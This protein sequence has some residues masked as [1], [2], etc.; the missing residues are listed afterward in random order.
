MQIKGK[1]ALNE[2]FITWDEKRF[3]SGEYIEDGFSLMTRNTSSLGSMVSLSEGLSGGWDDWWCQFAGWQ[4]ECTL[5]VYDTGFAPT[6]FEAGIL[7]ARTA[8][9][10]PEDMEK[11][12]DLSWAM[13]YFDTEMGMSAIYEG[14][15]LEPLSPKFVSEVTLTDSWYQYPTQTNL[16]FILRQRRIDPSFGKRIAELFAV[17]FESI[18]T[19]KDVDL[20]LVE[21]EAL[22][23]RTANQAREN[24]HKV[25]EFLSKLNTWN[26]GH[27][28]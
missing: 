6:L 3:G 26:A 9:T 13:D 18:E 19:W 15:N 24:S 17:M 28:I 7:F 22:A 5:V 4:G 21:P 1:K 27:R 2:I 10:V 16:L 14:S 23:K 20:D 25:D 12:E 11:I 8:R